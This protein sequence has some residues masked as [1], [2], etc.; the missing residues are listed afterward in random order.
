MDN[1]SRDR[2]SFGTALAAI[3]SA[4]ILAGIFVAVFGSSISPRPQ[5]TVAAA[6]VGASNENDRGSQIAKDAP[7]AADVV[8]QR[9]AAVTPPDIPAA[10]ASQEIVDQNNLI[11]D[12]QLPLET[13]ALPVTASTTFPSTYKPNRKLDATRR[14]QTPRGL[15][16]LQ[17]G[18]S[19]T[20]A[21]FFS[22]E[23]RQRL[24]QRYGN[25]GAGSFLTWFARV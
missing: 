6:R 14:G 15:T 24:Q 9:S 19:H 5:E 17:I 12:P 18:D 3:V 2:L 20:S 10:P 25:G 1:M 11:P 13:N 16:I 8:T 21:D 7:G 22:G 23:L 4:A